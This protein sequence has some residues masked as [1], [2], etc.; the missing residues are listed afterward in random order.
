VD[1][2]AEDAIVLNGNPSD[3]FNVVDLVVGTGAPGASP[4]WNGPLP[5]RSSDVWEAPRALSAEQLAYLKGGSV[6]VPVP[7]PPA[8]KVPAY[9]AIGGD[10]IAR[11]MI[12]R[13][14]AADYKEAGQALNEG[15]AV[16][17]WRTAYDAMRDII[18]GHDA[19]KSIGA[20]IAAHR[21]EWRVALGLK[22][23]T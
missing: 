20:S 16:W 8:P 15:S 21:K 18:H 1:G 14:L 2:Y 22:E 7:P 13:A 9:E 10:Q 4:G 6:G 3:L 5:R 17:F 23:T 19:M 12:G 11:D